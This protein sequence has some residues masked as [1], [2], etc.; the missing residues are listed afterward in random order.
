MGKDASRRARG[1]AGEKS[2]FSAS[3]QV[4]GASSWQGSNLDASLWLWR[5]YQEAEMK[6]D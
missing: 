3:C 5:R 6:T 2:G 1:R 4:L